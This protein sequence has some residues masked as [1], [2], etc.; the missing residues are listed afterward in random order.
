MTIK[1]NPTELVEDVALTPKLKIDDVIITFLETNTKGTVYTELTSKF[2]VKLL[3]GNKNMFLY[4]IIM[5][6]TKL[7]TAL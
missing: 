7:F 3:K 4:Y 6:K 5:N 2:H 1:N